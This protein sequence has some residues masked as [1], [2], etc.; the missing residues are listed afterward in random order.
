MPWN[1]CSKLTSFR[2]RY[3]FRVFAAFFVDRDRAAA[4]RFF[5]AY[6][7]DCESARFDAAL[8]P[9]PFNACEAGAVCAFSTDAFAEWSF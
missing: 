5:G 1:L 3:F 9:S 8:R 4:E 7:P 6:A 2:E